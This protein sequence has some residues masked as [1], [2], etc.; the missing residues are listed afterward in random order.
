MAVDAD[1][2]IRLGEAEILRGIFSWMHPEIEHTY[3]L[4][5]NT[6]LHFFVRNFMVQLQFVL[7]I[8]WF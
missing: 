5:Q 6:Y 4:E 2:Y 3:C 8:S 7:E 1:V